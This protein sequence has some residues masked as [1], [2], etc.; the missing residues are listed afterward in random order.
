MNNGIYLIQLHCG[1]KLL[2]TSFAW[3]SI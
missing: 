2:W 1:L 3:H